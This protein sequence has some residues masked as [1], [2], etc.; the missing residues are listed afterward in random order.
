MKKLQYV[1]YKD[2]MFQTLGQQF[3]CPTQSFQATQAS[4]FFVGSGPTTRG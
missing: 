3:G 1:V 4:P 2:Q